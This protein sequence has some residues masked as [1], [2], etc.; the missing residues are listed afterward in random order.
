M[1]QLSETARFTHGAK[2]PMDSLGIELELIPRW[3]QIQTMLSRFNADGSPPPTCPRVHSTF[4][5]VV[6]SD[7][8]EIPHSK[9]VKNS[10]LSCQT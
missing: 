4:A 10:N 9:T 6:T 8:K 2:M 5:D 3:Y 1:L 7:N